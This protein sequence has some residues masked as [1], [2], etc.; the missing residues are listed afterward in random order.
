[1][2]KKNF[3]KKRIKKGIERVVLSEILPYETPPIFSNKQFYDF[4]VK[5]NIEIDGNEITCKNDDPI[6][7]IIKRL[8]FGFRKYKFQEKTIPFK[9]KISHKDNNFRELTIIHPKNQLAMIDFYRKYKELI[10]YYCNIS[11][12][13]I[14]KP[15]SIAKYSYYRELEYFKNLS[16][17]HENKSIQEYEKEY[18]PS[19]LFLSTKIIVMFINFMNLI[20]IRGVKRNTI[21]Y[22]NLIFQDVLIASILILYH[23]H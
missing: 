10:L 3:K 7:E 4:L 2:K 5:N 8:L 21:S 20:D 11:P 18:E 16:Y 13:S 17:E 19:M 14:R 6:L 23:G 12:F 1:M 22:L 15:V 9:Y